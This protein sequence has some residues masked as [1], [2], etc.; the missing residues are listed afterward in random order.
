MNTENKTKVRL[1]ADG[2]VH[3]FNLTESQ[4]VEVTDAWD[5]YTSKGNNFVWTYIYEESVT[6]EIN[7]STV[8]AI[9]IGEVSW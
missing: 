5:A 3:E 1:Y 8:S 9:K 6:F 7:I 2:H 4:V